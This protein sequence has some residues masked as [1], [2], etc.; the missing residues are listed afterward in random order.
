MGD[1]KITVIPSIHSKPNMF[2]DDLGKEI[3]QPLENPKNLKQYKEG[4]SYDF[5]IEHKDHAK[6]CRE[7]RPSLV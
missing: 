4:G 1:F 6:N 5:F 3:K 7:N 2:N